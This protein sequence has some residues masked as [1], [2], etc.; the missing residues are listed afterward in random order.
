ML[1]VAFSQFR[2]L[3]VHEPLSWNQN[4]LVVSLL[5]TIQ[6]NCTS[7]TG[8]VSHK[9]VLPLYRE[10]CTFVRPSRIDFAL[11]GMP[12]LRSREDDKF[13]SVGLERIR[14]IQ[15]AVLAGSLFHEVEILGSAD[16]VALY[17]E[18]AFAPRQIADG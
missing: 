3:A 1:P 17:A 12:R 8:S 11:R 9:I 7:A 15:G 18:R 4:G 13:Q 16:S 2:L 6:S 5:E 14:Q 10:C